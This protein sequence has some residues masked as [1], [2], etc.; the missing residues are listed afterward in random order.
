MGPRLFSRGN[1]P[2][3][4]TTALAASAG[5]NGAATLQPRKSMADRHM[6]LHSQLQWGRDFSRGNRGMPA[7]AKR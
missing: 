5:F 2:G 1:A 7:P 6:P 4:G 3:D